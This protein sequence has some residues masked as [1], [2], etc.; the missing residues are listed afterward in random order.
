MTRDRGEGSRWPF[1]IRWEKETVALAVQRRSFNSCPN[2]RVHNFA[3]YV[4]GAGARPYGVYC[5]GGEFEV[6]PL[7]AID[8][9]K[10]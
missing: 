2:V 8:I 10:M 6:T 7:H 9:S 3:K 4:D 1:S 5:G